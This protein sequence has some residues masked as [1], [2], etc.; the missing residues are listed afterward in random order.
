MIK[1]RVWQGD[2]S[3]TCDPAIRQTGTESLKMEAETFSII[4][5]YS[6][7]IQ[8]APDQI[9]EVSYWV[10]TDLEIDEAEIYGRVIAA[11]YDASAQED[12]QVN[13]N[14]IDPGFTL[15]EN[16][17]PQQDWT[18]TSYVF[19]TEPGTAYV[20]L[21]GVVGGPTGKARGTTWFDQVAIRKR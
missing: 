10:K 2:M 4:E 5:S 19:V 21:R 8:V 15:G 11:Q 13:E 17:D 7:L 3:R 20:R 6:P 14:R 9:Y 12:D 16:P 18:F 1:S